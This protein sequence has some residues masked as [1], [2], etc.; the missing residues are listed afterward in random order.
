MLVA[1]ALAVLI[2]VTASAQEADQNFSVRSGDGSL[3]GTYDTQEQAEAAIRTIPGPSDAPDA[4]QYVREIKNQTVSEDGKTTITYWMGK[5]DR[6]F[7]FY[8]MTAMPRG[9][10]EEAVS[11]SIS[12]LNQR[13]SP[14]CPSASMNAL[15]DWTPYS[16]E[17]AHYE[18]RNYSTNYFDYNEPTETCEPRADTAT[19]SRISICPTPY[20]YWSSSHNACVNEEITASIETT[21]SQCEDES[22]DTG[23]VG[24]PCDVKT[25]NKYETE[26]DFDLGWAQLTRYYHSGVATATGGFG[27][28]WSDT[29]RIRL[30][31]NLP[32]IG[33]IEGSGYTVPF[34]QVGS[35]YHA[36][37]GSGD[38]IAASGNQWKLYRQDAVYIFNDIGRLVMRQPED[39]NVLSYAY[40]SS[41]RLD[42]I[43][44]PQ[45]R[46]IQFQYADTSSDSL[47]TGVSSHGTQLA[48]YTYENGRLK[49]VTYQ[50]GGTRTYH[51]ED[52]RFPRHLTGITAEDGQRYSTFAYD[53]KGRA[54]SSQHVGGTDGVALSYSPAGTVVTDALGKQTS[55]AMA[56]AGGGS[57]KVTSVTDS[58][59]TIAYQY[60]GQS[61]DFRRRVDTMTDRKG[62]QIKHSYSE[63]TDAVTGQPASVHTVREAYGLPEERTREERRDL[64][65]NRAL[66][67]QT[68]NLE[69]RYTYNARLQPA[70]ITARDTATSQTRTT[71]FAYCE[72]ADVAAPSSTCPIEGLLKSVDGPRTDVTDLVIYAYYG[73]DDPGCTTS[74]PTCTH[75]KGDLW[76]ITTALGHV[77]ETLAYDPTGQPLSVKN[78]NGIVTDF[79]YHPRGWLMARK[80]RGTNTG[81]EADDQITMIEYWPTGLVK[82][83]IQSDGAFTSYA[84]DA[85]QRLTDVSD[86]I[87]NTIHYSLDLA[88]NRLQEDTKDPGSVLK[89]TLSR[90][91]NQLGQLQTQADAQANPTDFTYDAN[92]NTN[93]V[94]DALGRVTDNDYDPLNRLSRALQNVGGINAETKFQYDAQDN[95]TQVTDPKGLNT[96]Y[97]Y[98]G[99]GDLTQLVSP[100]TGTTTYTF[101]SAGNRISKLDANDPEPH[102]YLYDA[103]NRLIS[104]FYSTTSGGTSPDVRYT[105]DIVNSECATDETFAKGRLTAAHAEATL[106]YCYDRFGNLTRKVQSIGGRTF[107]LRY[108]YTKA[109]QLQ[110]VTYPDGAVADYVRDAQG[111][112]AEV[113][114]TR[115]DGVR[116]ILLNQT[117]YAPFGPLVGWTYGNGRQMQRPLNQNYRPTAIHD[118]GVGGLDVGFGFDA[119]GNL[120]QLTPAAS[121]TPL[122]K[123]DYDAL[124]RLTKFKDGPTDVAIESYAYDATGNRQSFTNSA[125]TQTYTYPSTNHRLAQVGAIARTYDAVGNTISIGGIA[126]E[127]GYSQADRLSSVKQGGAVT[128]QYGYNAL[129]ER[130]VNVQP[131]LPSNPDGSGGTPSVSTYFVYDETGHWL[132]QYDNAASA[133]QQIVWLDDLPVGL[134]AN[135]NQLHYIEP[136]H[137]G[138]PRVVIEVL[139][140]VP[141]WTWDLKSEAFGNSVPNQDPDGDTNA[142]VFDMRFPG[143]RYDVATGMNQNYFRDYD[144]SSGRYAQS[145]PIGFNGGI[146]TYAYVGGNPISFVDPLGLEG[147]GPWWNAN[148][149]NQQGLRNG[150]ALR[151]T[152][153]RAR[154]IRDWANSRFP[155]VPG[156]PNDP[157]RHCVTSCMMARDA[158]IG[159]GMGRTLGG[160]NEA[161]GFLQH[162]L[163]DLGSKLRNGGPWAFQKSDLQ[164]NEKGFCSGNSLPGPK[165]TNAA[166]GEM[167]A[168]CVQQ[169]SK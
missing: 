93:T 60:Y 7:M 118:P 106:K 36:A 146:N 44:S 49:T 4:Y 29:H 30:E 129:G 131:G 40:D 107:V 120:T 159:A 15:N 20:T 109:G 77:T 26:P 6:N 148:A 31:I 136:D 126:R 43:T 165:P 122:V 24:N 94:T 91:Y 108:A 34:R 138:T 12:Y 169:C 76:K 42:T 59:G 101:D 53:D 113:G 153:S 27:S 21:Q 139:R 68:G 37:S 50:G 164:H 52:T 54:V 45:G 160:A 55:Y 133:V 137:L 128:M 57:P 123:F 14:P 110:S 142:L 63:V 134:I 99:L 145:D 69:T 86:N 119:V 152:Y 74:P 16:P 83:V 19:L 28:G 114:V 161:W 98:N 8:G 167:G 64:A 65:S 127:F 96:T 130:V 112:V 85:A 17:L 157:M 105:Y 155:R 72:A 124:S 9:T 111:R 18:L 115:A 97:T 71:S 141:V 84:Y 147:F 32:V 3:F 82:K 73:S 22:G 1:L 66:L 103:L 41:G 2:Q 10:E 132:G 58:A 62:T 158:S 168:Q 89:R 13:G 149:L 75:R 117:S 56:D 51:Y 46:S 70:S 125:G 87:G 104:V 144:P 11:D 39:G 5:H 116:A 156:D 162:D 121:A 154:S 80:V 143:Q 23:L 100:D 81:S 33:L 35:E 88:G 102:T 166:L 163:P 79:E 25:G 38:R 140:N 92:G 78:P 61:V 48:S 47:I 95:L 67:L 90:V 150:T 151:D 135:G